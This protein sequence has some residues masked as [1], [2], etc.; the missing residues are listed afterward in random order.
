[1]YRGPTVEINLANLTENLNLVRNRVRGRDLF[2]VV[3]ADAYGHGIV[4]VS[5]RLISA[6]METLAV[7]FISEALHLRE[8][9]IKNPIL[10]FF[11]TENP[12]DIVKLGL[13]PVI[14]NLETAVRLSCQAERSSEVVDIHLNV[15]TGMGR[16]GFRYE[17]IERA[18]SEIEPLTNIRV[19]GLMSH[20]SDADIADRSFAE[21]QVERFLD[22]KSTLNAKG[23]NPV[24]HIA[25]SA[26]VMT[27][28]DALLDAVR[29][30]LIL[31]G[32]NPFT[33][34][35]VSPVMSVKSELLTLRRVSSGTPISYG[36]TFVTER[37]SLIGVL[38]L[39]Y[40]DG[41]SRSLSNNA[42]V[43]V[44]GER[45][46]VI[47]RICM[48]LTMVDLTE[49]DDVR[50]SDEVVIIG[51]QGEERILVDEVA[52]R[53]DTIPYEVMTSMGS[54]GRR[55]YVGE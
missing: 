13:T 8:S 53:A 27:Y 20:F 16:I 36:R 4:E 54:K 25:N 32:C 38:P 52:G 42:D 47:G 33:P 17:D 12:E 19:A 11:G 41:L 23:I 21:L 18:L 51:A 30:G 10:V 24:C 37:E 26:A 7:A 50:E 5:R 2:A 22:V 3:K 39:G 40:A 46:P 34:D 43:L 49:V 1:M 44:R 14:N 35:T 55:V 45:V 48:D 29:P 15:D 6:G 28:P 31:Y 9:G